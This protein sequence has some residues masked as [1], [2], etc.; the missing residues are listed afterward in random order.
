MNVLKTDLLHAEV[1]NAVLQ[2]WDLETELEACLKADAL[3]LEWHDE[4]TGILREI[5]DNRLLLELQHQR[6]R[7]FTDELSA[8]VFAADGDADMTPEELLFSDVDSGRYGRFVGLRAK[9]TGL[10]RQLREVESWLRAERVTAELRR[11]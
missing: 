6:L 2:M 5:R 8:Y 7:A 1:R 9:L 11:R 4:A 3:P 10:S